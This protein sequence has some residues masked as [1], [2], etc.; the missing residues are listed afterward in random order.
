MRYMNDMS[1]C[2]QNLTWYELQD[3]M[4]D[5]YDKACQVCNENMLTLCD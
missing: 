5:V 4:F 3:E 2:A 1:D